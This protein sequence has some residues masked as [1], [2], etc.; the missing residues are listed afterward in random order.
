MLENG[1][2]TERFKL[3]E[4][5]ELPNFQNGIYQVELN[6]FPYDNDCQTDNEQVV[7]AISQLEATL[8]D[9]I[10]KYENGSARIRNLKKYK[11]TDWDISITQWD[12]ESTLRQQMTMLSTY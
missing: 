7:N 4:E 5:K 3:F 12:S 9:S 6:D 1:E 10:A 11:K 8:T 2:T